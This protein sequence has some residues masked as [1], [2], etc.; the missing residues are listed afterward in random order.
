LGTPYRYVKGNP[1]IVW[2]QAFIPLPLFVSLQKKNHMSYTSRHRYKNRREKFQNTKRKTGI[3]L[4]IILIA[5][6]FLAIYNWQT[7][8]DWYVTTFT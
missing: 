7:L 1:K 2:L 8:K 5:L 6:I 3:V 4:M